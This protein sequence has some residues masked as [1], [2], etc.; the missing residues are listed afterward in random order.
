M[1]RFEPNIAFTG[2]DPLPVADDDN[3]M[4]TVGD[5]IWD[6][7]K[8]EAVGP[9]TLSIEF[10][11][12]LKG[13]VRFELSHLFGVFEKLKDSAYFEQ[14]GI[15]HGTVSW[16]NEEPDLAPDTMYDAIKA[17]GVWILN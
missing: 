16:P 8:V 1:D 7:V 10:E 9:L 13:Q 5:P 6:V 12:G 15:A 3:E 14:V 4:I 17:H 11:D 2:M